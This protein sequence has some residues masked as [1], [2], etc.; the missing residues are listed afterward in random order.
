[1]SKEILSDLW[2][3]IKTIKTK[4]SFTQNVSIVFSGNVLNFILQLVISPIISRIFSPEAYGE[5]AYYNLIVTNILFF[6]S[7]SLSSV[8]VLPKF[9]LDFYALL[10]LVLIQAV[11]ASIIALTIFLIADG[12]LFNFEGSILAIPLI[13]TM[14][15]LEVLNGGFSSFNIREKRFKR[16][17]ASSLIANIISRVSSILIG[18][19]AFANGIGL[20]LGDFIRSISLLLTQT[21]LKTKFVF[22]KYLFKPNIR[23][24]KEVFFENINVPKFIFPVQLLNKWA[25]D[26][27]LIA[28]GAFYSIETVGAYTFAIALLNIPGRLFE[29]SLRPVFF[30]K[31]NEVY[32]ENPSNLPSLFLKTFRISFFGSLIPTTGLSLLAPVIFPFVFGEEWQVAGYFAMLLGIKY[33]IITVLSPYTGFWRIMKREK[34][35]FKLNTLSLVFRLAPLLL[36]ILDVG[37]Y[38]F[39]VLYAIISSFGTLVNLTDLIWVLL[40]KNTAIKLLI[41][42][43]LTFAICFSV[44]V[45]I[46]YRYHLL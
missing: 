13:L 6:S 41:G 37:V 43:V 16:N 31:A 30:Q 23:H 17:T 40:K 12:W 15:L 20:L 32:L 10:K 3:S 26:L 44:I 45:L 29:S 46:A 38:K 27:P 1:M 18:L 2:N 24:L 21:S 28:I 19:F 25:A 14:I 7:L 5:Y 34:Q 39:M 42:I 22:L 9:K 4:G 36:P 33:V 8:Y 35:L 11:V